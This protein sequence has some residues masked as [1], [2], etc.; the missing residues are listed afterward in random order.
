M[1]EGRSVIL[2]HVMC[3]G[4]TGEAYHDLASSELLLLRLALTVRHL[5]V[6]AG[7]LRVG[8]SLGRFLTTL[9]VLALAMMFRSH[10]VALSCAFVMLRCF[11][12]GVL[13]H[14]FL[15]ACTA[16]YERVDCLIVPCDSNLD[17]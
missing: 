3:V 4:R 6:F 17:V 8:L 16:L 15:L 9:C 10:L 7:S 2:R 11:V 5:R 13:G 12:V 14:V 1:P